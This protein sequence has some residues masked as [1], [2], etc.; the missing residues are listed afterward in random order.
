M[1]KILEFPFYFL[2]QLVNKVVCRF[3]DTDSEQQKVLTC[4]LYTTENEVSVL[5]YADKAYI[6]GEQPF[7]LTEEEITELSK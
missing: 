6:L 1:E 5:V 7:T 4:D 3:I 2:E